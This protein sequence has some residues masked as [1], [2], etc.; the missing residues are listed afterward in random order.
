MSTHHPSIGQRPVAGALLA[1]AAM[2]LFSVQDAIVKWLLADY[3]LFQ[4]M[5]LRS[6]T[7]IVPLLIIVFVRYGRRALHTRRPFAH[8]LQVIFYY[9]AFVTYF[10]AIERMPLADLSAITLS[11]PLFLTLLAG[12]VLGEVVGKRRWTAMIVGF[13]GVIIMVNPTASEVD[14]LGVTLALGTAICYACM[15]IQTRRLVTTERGEVVVCYVTLGYLFL[16]AG[17]S[18]PNWI[19]PSAFGLV[20]MLGLGLITISAQY[21][22]IKAYTLAP[23]SVLAPMDYSLLIWATVFGYAFWAETP[24]VHTLYGAPLVVGSGLYIVYREL[25]LR[26]L[27]T[28]TDSSTTAH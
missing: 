16:G 28:S 20:S 6:V 17:M 23:I 8:L 21:T 5:F 9:L 14:P 26:R 27:A 12:P 2:G 25:K 24:S 13:V 4:V 11:G 10:I 15:R 22:I 19:T 18:L 7:A 1:L 3:T